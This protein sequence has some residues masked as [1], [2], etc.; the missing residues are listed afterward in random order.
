M[1]PDDGAVPG[2]WLVPDKVRVVFF[3]DSTARTEYLDRRP[4]A[5]L[6]AEWLPLR[7]NLTMLENIA[8][9]PQFRQGLSFDAA[10]VR[11]MAL[12]ED[13]GCADSAHKRDPDLTREERFVTKLLRAVL[14]GPPIILVDRPG[15]Q[16]PD[17]PPAPFLA[18]TLSSL[19]AS[20]TECRV[21]E[22]AWNAPLYDPRA[23]AT[24]D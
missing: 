10:A 17:T 12:L 4:E 22:Y 8:L 24:S 2:V 15:L 16:L 3:P 14:Q 1:S 11:V 6:V 20:F 7:A 9:V 18:R 23:S 5:A 13:A 19:A 21:L